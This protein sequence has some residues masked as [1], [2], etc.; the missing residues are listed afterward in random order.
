MILAQLHDYCPNLRSAPATKGMVVASLVLAWAMGGCLVDEKCYADVDCTKPQVCGP[1]GQCQFQCRVDSDCDHVFG[2]EFVC[3]DHHCVRPVA[4]TVCSFPHAQA[5]CVH[6]VCQRGS[7]ELGYHDINGDPTDGCEYRCTPSGG[8]ACDGT[9]NDCDGLLDENTDL[10]ADP[11]NCGHCGNVCPSPP[12]AGPVCA[13]GQCAFNCHS[14]FHDNNGHADDGCESAA[15]V[16]SEEICDGQDNDC[17]CVTDSNGDGVLCGPDDVGVD[18][19]FDRT[20][21]ASCGPFCAV[22]LYAHAQARCTDGVCQIGA[23][24]A[25]WHNADG[26]KLNGCECSPTGDEQCDGLDND[27]DGLVDEEDVCHTTCPPDMVAVASKYCIDRY[28]ASRADATATGQG[29]D[30][31]IALSRAGVMPWMVNPM[32]ESHLAQFQ[33]ACT[34]AG[35]HLCT[36]DE[37]VAACTGPGQTPYVYGKVFDREACNC[38]DA[39]CDDY[40]SEHAIAPAQCS[41]ASDCGYTYESF[42]TAL[43]GEFAACTNEYGTFD[44]NGNV[45]EIVP[46]DSDPRGYEVRGGAFNCASAMQRVS[47]SFNASWTALYAGFR[48]CREV[49]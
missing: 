1:T 38:V 8:E 34:A 47:C 19:G 24:D 6:G 21:A 14:G 11:L 46:S 17:D 36:R 13:S 32:S 28:E 35:K 18:E 49:R 43:T 15:C 7:C 25:G 31:S 20:L 29:S 9:D 39:F 22:C 5:S 16:P 26:I 3:T 48:C 4:C 37:W 44:I 40:C 23:C 41:T 27:C 33:A 42:H 12:N 2:V 30:S 10:S 45:W